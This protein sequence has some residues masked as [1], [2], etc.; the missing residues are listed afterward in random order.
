MNKIGIA[1]I[2]G[3]A[4]ASG[5]SAQTWV[6]VGDA[7]DLPGT[8]QVVLGAGPLSQING[9]NDANDV[10]MFQIRIKD[11]A[12]F[13][14]TTVGGAAWDTQ[15][16]LF[17]MN[18]RGVSFNDDSASTA[19]STLTGMFVPS[20]GNYLIAISRYNRDALD[21]SGALIW[22]NTPFGTERAP[23]GP[24]AANP[25]ASWAGT[26]AAGGA[27]SIFLTSANFVPAPGAVALLGMSGL[28]LARRRR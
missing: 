12:L 24:G 27:Y 4:I 16:W 7:G 5:A 15:L 14:A 3:L 25:V 1:L 2:A 9:I 10:D 8:A 23:D 20:P 17:D 13:R 6:E 22:N 19:Q 21:G 18:G 26:T 11:P 28:L